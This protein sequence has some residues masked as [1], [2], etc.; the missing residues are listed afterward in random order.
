MDIRVGT[1][2]Y[3]RYRAPDGW[4]E[5]HASKIQVYTGAFETVGLNR[6]FYKLT[7]A[8]TAE[9][10]RRNAVGDFEFLL[11]ARQ[12]VGHPNNSPTWNNRRDQLSDRQKRRDRRVG[13]DGQQ[14]RGVGADTR[15][16]PGARGETRRESVIANP[17]E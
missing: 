12:A 8:K 14:L 13:S 7:R 9:E 15:C 5:T 10:W 2:G 3:G 16:R 6:T 4:K 11:K 17:L 1:C